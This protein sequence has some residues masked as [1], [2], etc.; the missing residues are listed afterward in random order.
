MTEYTTKEDVTKAIAKVRKLMFA[1]GRKNFRCS[2]CGKETP[3]LLDGWFDA[4]EELVLA[5]EDKTTG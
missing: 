3:I 2:H 5:V 4:V 1:K